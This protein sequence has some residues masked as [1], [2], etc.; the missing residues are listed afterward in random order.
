VPTILGGGTLEFRERLFALKEMALMIAGP[1]IEEYFVNQFNR[2]YPNFTYNNGLK[3]KSL[4][5]MKTAYCTEPYNNQMREM[6]YYCMNLMWAENGWA[7]QI[8]SKVM[9]FLRL[10]YTDKYGM[11]DTKETSQNGMC[12]ILLVVQFARYLTAFHCLHRNS[13][14]NSSAKKTIF[15]GWIHKKVDSCQKR[16]DDC[17]PSKKSRGQF[18]QRG[19]LQEKYKEE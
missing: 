18:S 19:Y 15:Q 16:C 6:I 13:C 3:V 2:V 10:C 14:S 4:D 12:L 17:P 5:N 8:E 7:T 11:C 9:A 1:R